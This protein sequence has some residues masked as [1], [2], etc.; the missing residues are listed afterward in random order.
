MINIEGSLLIF[1]K[2]FCVKTWK[3]Y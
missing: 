3:K 2:L 1:A